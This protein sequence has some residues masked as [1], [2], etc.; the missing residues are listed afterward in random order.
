M[1]LCIQEDNQAIGYCNQ[2][3]KGALLT[4][5]L[6]SKRPGVNTRHDAIKTIVKGAFQHFVDEIWQ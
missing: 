5:R 4:A 2:F 1:G 3:F 6:H